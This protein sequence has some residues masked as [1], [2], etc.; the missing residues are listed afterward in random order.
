MSVLITPMQPISAV[1]IF[2]ICVD[3]SC[4]SLSQC[5]IV[6]SIFTMQS[7]DYKALVKVTSHYALC[8]MRYAH[9]NG[10][11]SILDCTCKDEHITI[12]LLASVGSYVSASQ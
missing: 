2:H 4:S 5:K 3:H 8:Y 1:W 12:Y 11:Q 6:S 9:S 7:N 10:T